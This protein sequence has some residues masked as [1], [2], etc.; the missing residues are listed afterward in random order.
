MAGTPRDAHPCS[1]IEKLRLKC[2]ERGAAGIKGLSRTF[3][4]MDEDRSKSLDLQELLRGLEAYGMS[5][6]RDEAQHI[7]S[8]LDKDGGGTVD[9]SEFLEALRPPLSCS[10]RAVIT[11]AFSKLDR[12]GDGVV[13]VLDLQ[14]VYDATQHPKFRSGQWSEEEVFHAFLDSFDSPYDKDG[15]VTL[16]EFVNYYSGVSA[17]IDSD[18]YFVTM[19]RKA[20][21]L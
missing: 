3:R 2:L 12:S 5:V 16:E 4:I 14:G 6:S 1:T 20:W 18:E 7:L 13:T 17:S 9:F 10:R 19:V 8:T 21:K 15:K 11:A